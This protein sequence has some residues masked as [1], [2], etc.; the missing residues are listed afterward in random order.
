MQLLAGEHHRAGCVLAAIGGAEAESR[1]H[2]TG[3]RAEDAPDLELG[4]DRGGVHRPGAAEGKQGEAAGIDAALDG[5]DAQRPH[6]LLVGDAQDAFGGLDLIEAQRGGKGADSIRG[7]VRVE[8]H[9]A[10]QL[11]VGGE[12]AEQQVGVGDR[13]LAAAASVGGGPRIGAGRA[14]PDAQGAAAVAPADRAAAGADGVDVD[15]RQLDRAAGDRARVGPLHLARLDHADVARGPTHVE[16]QRVAVAGELGQQ[17]GAD[18]ASGR[19]REHA[20]GPGPGRFLGAGDAARGLHHQR[21]RQAGLAR[22]FAEP[23]QV[24]PEQRR[25]VGV[26]RGGRAALVLAEARQDLVRGGDVHARQLTAQVRGEA[27]L[28][29]RIEVGEEQADRHRLGAALA[30]ELG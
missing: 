24:T 5:D 19:A 27:L 22:G 23:L 13:G 29:G 11:R 21:S 15:H 12:P 1:E 8:G 26:D 18:G 17:P 7:R 30:Y 9:V 4:G 14:R 6:H 2:A 16:A 20:P 10:G 28:V 3:A 25:E